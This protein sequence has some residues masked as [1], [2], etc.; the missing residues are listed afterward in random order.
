M[1]DVVNMLNHTVTLLLSVNNISHHFEFTIFKYIYLLWF[2]YFPPPPQM[3]QCWQTVPPRTARRDDSYGSYSAVC[4]RWRT[5]LCALSVWRIRKLSRSSAATAPVPSVPSRYGSAICVANQS[6][7]RST[8][9]HNIYT[10]TPC[11]LIMAIRLSALEILAA[12]V[13]WPD[14]KMA[15]I[16]EKG[17][18]I[19]IC[20][21]ISLC[22]I[23]HVLGRIWLL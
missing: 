16:K 12:C 9:S 3:V 11:S 6:R 17:D 19:I 18:C 1:H 5:A 7:A 10:T 2:C 23:A 13:R 22:C 21:C 4:R 8:C 20:I 15:A 14:Y